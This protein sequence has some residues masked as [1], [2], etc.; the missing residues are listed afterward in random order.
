MSRFVDPQDWNKAQE[1][2]VKCAAAWAKAPIEAALVA[3]ADARLR[4]DEGE[5]RE[6]LDELVDAMRA[7]QR[8]GG[9]LA[10]GQR[11]ARAYESTSH[12]LRSV[13]SAHD[14]VR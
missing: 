7:R 11:T 9:A 1:A 8:R 14:A 5:Q 2:R 10:P 3:A 13:R 12:P 4:F 6:M